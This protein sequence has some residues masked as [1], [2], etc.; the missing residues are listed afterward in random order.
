MISEKRKVSKQNHYRNRIANGQCPR[1]GKVLD[2]EGMYCSECTAKTRKYYHDNVKF[3][4]E[5]GLCAYCG[6]NKVFGNEKT[7]PECRAYRAKYR[8]PP[9]EASRKKHNEASKRKYQERKKK[10]LCVKCG[11]RKAEENRACCRICLDRHATKER[12]RRPPKRYAER[13]LCR[14]GKPFMKGQRLCPECYQKSCE[15]LKIARAAQDKERIAKLH[16]YLFEKE[17]KNES[18]VKITP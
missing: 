3:F 4:K 13:G 9:S 17:E 7:C 18:W 5:K 1:C 14:C 11:K 15:S 6:K 2:R 10:G 8:Q 12:E 16:D